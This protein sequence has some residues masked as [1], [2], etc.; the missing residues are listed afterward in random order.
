MGHGSDVIGDAVECMSSILK[1]TYPFEENDLEG[2]EQIW[3]H[4]LINTLE[5]DPKELSLLL[6]EPPLNPKHEREK[7]AEIMFETFAVAELCLVST[8]VLSIY[9][10]GAE[11][12]TG[13]VLESGHKGTYAVP[14]YEGHSLKYAIQHLDVAGRELTKF[15]N[16]ILDRKGY[17]FS[18]PR[19]LST[20]QEIKEKLSLVKR[21]PQNRKMVLRSLSRQFSETYSLPDG[22]TIELEASERQRCPEALF[23]PSLVEVEGPGIHELAHNCIQQCP[24]DIHHDLYSNIV[25]S[26][27]T[28]LVP[29]LEDRLKL[30]IKDLA[31]SNMRVEVHALPEREHAVYAGGTILSSL[32]TFESEWVS[33]SEYEEHGANMVHRK[34]CR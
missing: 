31:P 22:Q 26:G 6:S 7:M 8:A 23:N 21:N 10:S 28:T 3:K 4:A 11:N 29:G 27:G 9:A 18:R 24:V 25:L 34:C 12:V 33:K 5:K 15:M 13:V 2:K 1:P 32:P 20:V 17:N 16:T 14:I 30:E 19:D